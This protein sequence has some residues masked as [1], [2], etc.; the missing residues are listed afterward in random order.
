MLR[1]RLILCL[2]GLVAGCS[3]PAGPPGPLEIGVRDT[4]G[5]FVAFN[6][7]ESVPVVL[8]AN[9]LNMIVPSVR[10]VDCDPRA[11]DVSVEVVVGGIVMAADIRGERVDMTADGPG[12]A[13]FDLR[14]PFQT[15][16]CC[17]NCSPGV[18]KA[19]LQDA[20]GKTFEGEV[21]IVLERAACPDPGVCCGDVNA[22]PDPN[23]T[24]VCQ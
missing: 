16:L 9:G 10:A 20:S 4:N 7:D 8:G 13:L 12:Y 3:S 22:C 1:Q 24:Q 23:L 19:H 15:D 17:Y 6:A 5:R 18:V 21:T 2:A 11:P 14:V